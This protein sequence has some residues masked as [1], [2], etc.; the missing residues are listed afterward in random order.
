MSSS[1]EGTAI[2]TITVEDADA[3]LNIQ[4]DSVIGGGDEPASNNGTTSPE[5]NASPQKSGSSVI[6]GDDDAAVAE[7]VAHGRAISIESGVSNMSERDWTTGSSFE[8]VFDEEE[9]KRIADKSRHERHNSQ[10]RAIRLMEEERM[11]RIRE[12]ESSMENVPEEYVPSITIRPLAEVIR[13]RKEKRRA[14]QASLG[15]GGNKV[16]VGH[17]HHH[18][19]S[20]VETDEKDVGLTD[21]DLQT[22]LLG[23]R[24]ARKSIG[25]DRPQLSDPREAPDHK[26]G[27]K[28]SGLQ[29][30]LDLGIADRNEE[31]KNLKAVLRRKS[32]DNIAL[33]NS[34]EVRIKKR[35]SRSVLFRQHIQ[36]SVDHLS[37][38]KSLKDKLT[39]ASSP[40]APR[41]AK[42]RSQR[43]NVSADEVRQLFDRPPL[44]QEAIKKLRKEC[45]PKRLK[46]LFNKYCKK[47]L[48]PGQT[49]DS[50]G[51]KNMLMNEREFKAFLKYY[52]IYPGLCNKDE[53]SGVFRDLNSASAVADIQ[54]DW[55]RRKMPFELFKA[56]VSSI[57]DL[58]TTE[59]TYRV[60]YLRVRSSGSDHALLQNLNA[61]EL[62]VDVDEDIGKATPYRRK[63]KL[64][65][66]LM[67]K[68]VVS[69]VVNSSGTVI[70]LCLFYTIGSHPLCRHVIF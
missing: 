49:F 42:T 8:P 7:A 35:P 21:E 59:E 4:V 26:A 50:I 45:A 18:Y 24:V 22:L 57:L 47:G 37:S 51:K 60:A 9:E 11:R 44:S 2:P 28:S 10:Q 13:E 33:K 39:L 69:C 46:D 68:F 19:E 30:M 40:A 65:K 5:A 70:I 25:G 32:K 17:V 55:S 27:G 6:D 64:R 52:E 41:H 36:H 54:K 66:S 23:E 14:S 48:P 63:A 15:A 53:V 31:L 67:G 58:I 38:V 43:V 1:G 16:E 62:A 34:L 29:K 3:T 20:V 61:A 56:F 12:M